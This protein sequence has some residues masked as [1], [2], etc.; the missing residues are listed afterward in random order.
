MMKDGEHDNTR[1]SQERRGRSSTSM[2]YLAL[3][4]DP[5]VQQRDG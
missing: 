2:P 5:Q 3:L 4:S 1:G